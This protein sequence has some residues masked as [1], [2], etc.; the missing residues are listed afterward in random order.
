MVTNLSIF[1]INF[2]LY[3]YT[4]KTA[5]KQ[6]Q[7][8]ISSIKNIS[9]STQLDLFTT[10]HVVERTWHVIYWLIYFF[11]SLAC[12]VHLSLPKEGQS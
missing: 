9:H 12:E 2:S 3:D 1:S 11:I 8:K 10:S 5:S 6:S 4:K 7:K